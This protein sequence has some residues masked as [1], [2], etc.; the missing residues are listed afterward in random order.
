[1]TYPVS[2]TVSMVFR[3]YI[4]NFFDAVEPEK[5][6]E[7]FFYEYNKSTS[8]LTMKTYTTFDKEWL[9][10]VGASTKRE[11]SGCYAGK[12]GEGFKIAS[13]VAYRDMKFSIQMESKDWT[14]SVT[15]SDTY[16]DKTKVRC[17]A[18]NVEERAFENNSILTLKGVD[19]KQFKD[20][21]KTLA[22]FYYIGNP[23]L[24]EALFVGRY[25][26]VYK[27]SETVSKKNSG[28][29]YANYQL[30]KNISLP[31]V[32]CNN[33]FQIDDDDDREREFLTNTDT[34]RCILETFGNLDC[35]QA[36]SVLLCLKDF[37]NGR[38]KNHSNISPAPFI[39][40]LVHIVKNK[41]SK[42]FQNQFKE[43]YVADFFPYISPHRKHMAQ[44]WFR[45]SNHCKKKRILNIFTLLG[46]TDIEDL[47]EE[48]DG[49][50]AL[51]LP[52][53]EE[54]KRISILSEAAG[55]YFSDLYQYQKLPECLII[56]NE[57]APVQ[58]LAHLQK[59]VF[60]SQNS[61][62]LT[63]K[64]KVESINLKRKV[65]HSGSFGEALSVYLHEL[66]HQYGGDCS[67]QFHRALLLMNK[68]ILDCAENLNSLAKR[69]EETSLNNN[70][71][72]MYGSSKE[73][74]Q[75]GNSNGLCG[76]LEI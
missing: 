25:H 72:G 2:W 13:L 30:R 39:E 46:I 75:A 11:H 27:V 58:G 53:P 68:R 10:Y 59:D 18:Y 66:L 14:L 1:M 47:C 61:Y 73:I 34:V 38:A 48:N 56:C 67:I 7:Q 65:L 16:I 55:L 51:K 23:R 71:G 5:F 49:F 22:D 6:G 21:K 17:M 4:Q 64:Y 3:D 32:I 69:W 37:W 42:T 44:V 43:Y 40:E 31:L 20:F 15:E 52:E 33:R 28:Y 19:S 8:T 57:S 60:H 24:G 26:A 74:D 62:G 63:I 35:D 12:F 36:F 9:Y 54:A 45:A 76:R 50:T 70:T 41:Y 29:L